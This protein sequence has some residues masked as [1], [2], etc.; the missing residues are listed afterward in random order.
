MIAVSI[1]G[2]CLLLG[3]VVAQVDRGVLLRYKFQPR[4]Q[5]IYRLQAEGSGNLSMEALA[6]LGLG[7]VSPTTLPIYV[8]YDM[9]IGEWV[10]SVD[11]GGNTTSSSPTDR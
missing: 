5:L 2:Y 3:W 1:A 11:T 9:L 7:D 4:Q 8:S 6:G 10:L